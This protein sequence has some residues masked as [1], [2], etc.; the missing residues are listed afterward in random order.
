MGLTFCL[1]EGVVGCVVLVLLHATVGANG[2]EQNI[3]LAAVAVHGEGGADGGG[4]I[5]VG[6]DQRVPDGDAARVFAH[7]QTVVVVLPP[8]H[9]EGLIHIVEGLFQVGG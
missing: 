7:G 3:G 5:E 4:E 2:V 9:G 1:G 8:Q 6:E